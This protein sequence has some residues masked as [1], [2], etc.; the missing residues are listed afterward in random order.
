MMS[1]NRKYKCPYCEYRNTREELV[2][3]VEKKHSDMIPENYTAARVVFNYINKKDSGKCIVCGKDTEWNEKNWKYN[4]LCGDKKCSDKLRNDYKKNMVK[5]HGKITLLDDPDHQTKMLANRSISGTYKFADGGIR[6][7][8]GSFEK[9][10]LEF[11]DQVLNIKSDELL[12]PG[13]VFEY[14]FNGKTLQ[15]ITDIYYIPANLVIEV[16][17]GGDNPNN[18]EMTEYREK[19][20]AKEKMIADTKAYNYLRLTNNNFQ[21]LLYVLAELKNRMIDDSKD[22]DLLISINEEVGGLPPAWA[23]DVYVVNYMAPNTFEKSEIGLM[24]DPN[25][26][27]IIIKEKDKYKIVNKKDVL[28]EGSYDLYRYE[29]NTLEDKENYKSILLSIKNE[30]SESDTLLEKLLGKKFICNNEV[31]VSIITHA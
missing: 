2:D 30:Q 18:R 16:K 13:P 17:D 26:D 3:H 22:I 5:V 29:L 10:A 1:S 15:W 12:T 24:K 25:S 4:R 19:Q 7:Y 31:A 23:H 27:E 14:K 11:M 9:K 28:K 8:T 6:T 21:Q 20:K